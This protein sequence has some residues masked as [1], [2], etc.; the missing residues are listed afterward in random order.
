[1]QVVSFCKEKGIGL[2]VIGPEVPLVNGLADVLEEAGVPT[3]G[4][5]AKAAQLEGSKAFMKVKN[6]TKSWP[7]WPHHAC[8]S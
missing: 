2:V 5:K 3:W 8:L 7:P 1:M 4:P 6:D